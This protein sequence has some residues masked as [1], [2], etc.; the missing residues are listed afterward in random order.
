M[1]NHIVTGAYLRDAG[2]ERVTVGPIFK[3]LGGRVVRV[4]GR[5]RHDGHVA[6]RTHSDD[7]EKSQKRK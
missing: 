1:E 2:S 4:R 5:R 3:E 7:D 6:T